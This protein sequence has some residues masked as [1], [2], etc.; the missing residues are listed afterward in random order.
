[1]RKLPRID[2]RKSVHISN[3]DRLT[4]V[5]PRGF[6]A[7]SDAEVIPLRA[8]IHLDTCDFQSKD[9]YLKQGYEI[10]GVLDNCPKGHKRYY[11][12]KMLLA[13]DPV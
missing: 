13:N 5:D 2:D 8:L 10:F 12:K 11:L 1:M 4:I 7:V 3:I 9:F 6:G